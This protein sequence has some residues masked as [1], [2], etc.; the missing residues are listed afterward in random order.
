MIWA[1]SDDGLVHVTKD[2]GQTWTNVSPKS[3]PE[4]GRVYQ[5]DAVALR[6]AGRAISSTTCTS[7]ATGSPTSIRTTDYGATWT[8]IAKG[9]PDDGTAYV[10]REN[11]NKKGFLVVGTDNGLSLLDGRGRALEEVVGEISR[12]CRCGI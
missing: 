6:C 7:S 8:S 9:L 1:G 3:A 2:G 4:W 10:V 11:P 5:I 12:R